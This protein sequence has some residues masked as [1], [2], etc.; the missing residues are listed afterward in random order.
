MSGELVPSQFR[1]TTTNNRDFVIGDPTDSNLDQPKYLVFQMTDL[2]GYNNNPHI[3]VEKLAGNWKLSISENGASTYTIAYLEKNNV[4]TG[5]NT[6]QNITSFL[7]D[8]TG[9]EA[10]F[11]TLST[12][13]LNV[14]SVQASGNVNILGDL[15]VTGTTT[16]LNVA[17]VVVTD[18][19]IVLNHSGSTVSTTGSGLSIEGDAGA[20]VAGITLTGTDW[21]F[22]VPGRSNSIRLRPAT[23][24]AGQSIISADNLSS[25]QVHFL[26]QMTGTNSLFAM[27][28]GKSNL[29]EV[30]SNRVLITDANRG[31]DTSS[32][33]STE[34]GY[35]SGVTSA[36]QTQLNG[37]ASTA[38]IPDISGKADLTYVNSHVLS[39]TT[40]NTPT[41]G[42][43]PSFNGTTITWVD[44]ADPDT[45]FDTNA[46]Y[47]VWGAWE[48]K[49]QSPKATI[50]YSNVLGTPYDI[51]YGHCNYTYANGINSGYLTLA[52]PE[53]TSG[54]PDGVSLFAHYATVYQ[55]SNWSARTELN[56]TYVSLAT[57]NVA[58]IRVAPL[59][60]NGVTNPSGSAVVLNDRLNAT[61]YAIYFDNGVLMTSPV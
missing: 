44:K 25:A 55:T 22:T 53:A 4:F 23:N 40:T 50:L 24:A 19:N 43:V 26:P 39:Y 33:T 9:N 8:V 3:K 15:T 41:T 5:A 17:N 10:T 58:A 49:P 14:G 36:I 6:F 2:P 35:L 21:S 30:T 57:S 51:R 20:L 52:T 37:K 34:L 45:G 28:T 56:L 60:S 16:Q 48:F 11:T 29:S 18:K 13:G 1:Y 47:T 46:D 32:V 54:K 7:G 12:T 27:Y 42:Q 31:L 38:S 59:I 61:N